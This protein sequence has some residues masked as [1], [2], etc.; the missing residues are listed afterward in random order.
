MWFRFGSVS[1]SST[2]FAIGPGSCSVS[3]PA[4]PGR[5]R[6][7]SVFG[8]FCSDICFFS[9]VGTANTDC[10]PQEVYCFP[11]EVS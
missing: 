11:Q 7:A 9:G 2:V 3:V 1:V 5:F 8:T 6:F 10:F 4:V